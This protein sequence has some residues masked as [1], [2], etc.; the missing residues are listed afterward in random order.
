MVSALEAGSSGALY[1]Q[2]R[3]W[4]KPQASLRILSV[5]LHSEYLGTLLDFSE[6]FGCPRR[7]IQPFR[8]RSTA[9]VY[10]RVVDLKLSQIGLKGG[11]GLHLSRLHTTGARSE[12]PKWPREAPKL[13]VDGAGLLKGRF[14]DGAII[15]QTTLDRTTT[16]EEDRAQLCLDKLKFQK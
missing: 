3:V 14:R 11:L 12:V 9:A 6:A 1:E 13:N 15:S 2:L 16:R 4:I 8:N 5:S 7:Y 10:P